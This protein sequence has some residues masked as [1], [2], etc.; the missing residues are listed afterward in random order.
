MNNPF[1]FGSVAIYLATLSVFGS[2]YSSLGLRP[3]S[4]KF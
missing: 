1:S 4:W 2:F 3:Y